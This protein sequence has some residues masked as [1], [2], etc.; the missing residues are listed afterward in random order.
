MA[1][2]PSPHPTALSHGVGFDKRRYKRKKVGGGLGE[3]KKTPRN[4]KKHVA[5]VQTL[6]LGGLIK[7]GRG[8][9][10][11]RQTSLSAGTKQAHGEIR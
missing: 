4:I 11:K 8:D 6:A 2:G 9:G 3:K 1:R 7:G 10:G 5:E